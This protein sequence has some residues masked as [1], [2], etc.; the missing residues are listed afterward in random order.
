MKKDKKILFVVATHGN[1]K[2]GLEVVERLK[3][4]GYEKYFD[5]LV[6][7]PKAFQKN[8]RFVD[9]DLNRSYPG[10]KYSKFYE[11]RK[12][13]SNLTIEK[14]YKYVIDFHEASKGEND[15]VI[16]P[17][18]KLSKKFPLQYIDLDRVLLWPDPKGP[19]SQVLASAIELEFGMKNREREEVISV[20]FKIAKKFIEKIKNEK[21]RST[22]LRNK[23]IY[24]V[25][26][27]LTQKEFSG[28]MNFLVDFEEVEIN[29]ELFFP[30]L[31]KQYIKYGIVCY[32]MKKI[33]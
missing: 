33:Q 7:N 16:I 15:F 11:K 12:A 8:T 27:N 1:E 13:F 25:Y 19:M 18:E 24:Y 29:D 14:K 28:D 2:I 22:D 23:E 10:K 26:G 5:C 4:I 31:V 20:A 30:L 9:A 17:R 6:A 3:R 21:F 32:K